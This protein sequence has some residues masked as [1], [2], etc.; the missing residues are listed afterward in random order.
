MNDHTRS[1]RTQAAE[2]ILG[3][4]VDVNSRACLPGGGGGGII[5]C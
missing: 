4:D 1:T 3:Y 5:H 2:K